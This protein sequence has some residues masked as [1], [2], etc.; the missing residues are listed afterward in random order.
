MAKRDYY[1]VLGVGKTASAARDQVGIPQ[2]GAR[3]SIPTAIPGDTLA[4]ESFKEA[5]EAYAVLSDAD[6]RARYDRFGHQ[7][8]GGAGAGGFDPNDLRRLLGHPGRLLRLRGGRRPARRR[9]SRHGPRRRPALRPDAHR[10]RRPPSAPARRCASRG[11]RPAASARGSG[12]ANG[13]APTTCSAC[14]G[15]G[16]V[17]FTQGFFTVARTC[18]QC[19]GEGQGGHRSVQRVPGRG[20][21]RAG[22]LDRG[23]DPGRGRHRRPPAPVRRG[24]ARPPRRPAGRPLRGPPGRARTSASAATARRSCRAP[25]S[26]IRRR[27]WAPASR[28]RRCTATRRSRSRPAPRTAAT[29]AC[30]ARASTAWTAA[31]AATTW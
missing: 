18:P 7:G 30:A 26:A 6:K 5:A 22:A 14:G 28:W 17:R 23:E 11:S 21:G 8:V 20:A 4:E 29:S 13:A 12:S 10:S 1:E 15:R 31:A 3:N 27:C 16:Q 2:D 24:R 19:Q 25:R 9:P